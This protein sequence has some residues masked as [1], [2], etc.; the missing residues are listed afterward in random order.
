MKKTILMGALIVIAQLAQAAPLDSKSANVSM[1]VGKFARISGLND[2]VLTPVTTDGDA[3]SIYSGADAFN[4]EANC[5]VIMVLSGGN[6][7]NGRQELQTTY[8]LDNG[9]MNVTSSDPIHNKQH[10]VSASAKLGNISAQEAG[11][12]AAQISI[13]V[14]AL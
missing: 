9:T 5:P 6:L 7:S 2:F 12:Y 10:E 3:F 14:S 13:T 4:L 1:Q 11:A 8:K